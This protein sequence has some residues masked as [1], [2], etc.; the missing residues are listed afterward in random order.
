[1]KAASDENKDDISRIIKNPLRLE[2]YPD[3]QILRK[4]ACPVEIFGNEVQILA[5][6]MLE[7]MRRN[8]GVGLAAP[9]IGLSRRI[10]VIELDNQSHCMVNPE[11][12]LASDWDIMEEGCLSLPGKTVKVKRQKVAQIQGQDVT[13]KIQSFVATG[14]LAR[15]FQHEIDH[16]NGVLICDYE[17]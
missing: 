8:N 6:M 13:G 10:I 7:F 9:Q 14:L 16:L 5:N 3:S 12:S 15:A 2:I 4:V 11:I 1:M 17:T